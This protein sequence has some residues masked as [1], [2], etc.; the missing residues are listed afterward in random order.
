MFSRHHE[1]KQAVEKGRSQLDVCKADLAAKDAAIELLASKNSTLEAQII[2]CMTSA[3]LDSEASL[4]TKVKRLSSALT[5]ARRQ[6]Q[7]VDAAIERCMEQLAQRNVVLERLVKELE[8]CTIQ[9]PDTKKQFHDCQRL[10]LDAERRFA[11]EKS[12]KEALQSELG[13][14]R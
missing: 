13:E 2:S 9:L 10:L 8:A 1:V 5:I 4:Q 3:C 14:V 11:E 12:L 7:S 6:K